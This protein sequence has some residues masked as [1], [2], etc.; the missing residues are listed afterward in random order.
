MPSNPNDVTI[1]KIIGNLK[2][3]IAI[4]SK[5]IPKKKQTNK[6]NNKIMYTDTFNE[7][8]KSAK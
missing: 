7:V 5:N 1:G 2:V 3:I 4:P 6:I 8:A